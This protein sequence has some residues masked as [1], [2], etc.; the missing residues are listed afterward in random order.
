M[1]G[2]YSLDI[3]TTGLDPEVCQITAIGLGENNSGPES[4]EIYFVESPY[5][6]SRS[7]EWLS[8]RLADLDEPTIIAW[9]P[10]DSRFINTRASALSVPNPLEKTNHFDLHAWVRENKYS[11]EEVHMQD[12]MDDLE[13]G[14]KYLPGRLMPIFYH[15]YLDSGEEEEKAKIIKHCKGDVEA[16][17]KI[18][19]RYSDL[20]EL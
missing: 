19:G 1:T 10:F 15:A 16:M 12:V 8:N 13:I 7:L 2:V 9:R 5:E 17:M 18:A 14:E 20:P 6:E 3:E 11:G 4:I